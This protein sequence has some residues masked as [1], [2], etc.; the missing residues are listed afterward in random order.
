MD[1]V[2]GDISL[3]FCSRYSLDQ[4][5]QLFGTASLTKVWILLE[6]SLHWGAKA[7]PE[8]SL[9][10]QVK[11]V[12]LNWTSRIAAARLV[13]IQ[14]PGVSDSGINLY[15]AIGEQ[16]H[17]R[18][19]HTSLGAYEELLP[20]DLPAAIESSDFSGWTQLAEQLYLVCTNGKRD[21]CCA[22]FGLLSYNRLRSLAKTRV[23]QSTH[24]GGHRFAPNV[25]HL[26]YGIY[27]GRVDPKHVDEFF[28]TCQSGKISLDHYRGRA[29]YPPPVQA[30]EY[31]LRR[32]GGD[33]G[34]S[35]FRVDSFLEA[36][37]HVWQVR[38]TSDAGS[39]LYSIRLGYTS[40][41]KLVFKSCRDESPEF[42]PQF[43]LLEIQSE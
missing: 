9:P 39:R 38:F 36:G 10:E 3:D 17:P 31:Y 27:Y 12:L 32:H 16:Q 29:C 25:I 2:R 23:W 15:V 4:D 18:L 19:Y 5:E 1:G 11:N 40:T 42:T 33:D 22:K 6:Y 20:M 7:L 37:H 30:A 26:P 41:N 24:V 34:L 35:T 13:F 8:S 21:A 28:A 43:Q 14:R